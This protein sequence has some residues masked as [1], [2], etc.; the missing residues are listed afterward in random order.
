MGYVPDGPYVLNS[1]DHANESLEL[2]A[3]NDLGF[4]E[5]QLGI[6]RKKDKGK[7]EV[8]E[9]TKHLEWELEILKNVKPT[10]ICPICE[11]RT[12]RYF[13]IQTIGEY[14]RTDEN[15]MCCLG[16]R[17]KLLE[18]A[19]F[20]NPTLIPLAFPAMK[21]FYRYNY[22]KRRLIP[23]PTIKKI[24]KIFKKAFGIEKVNRKTMFEWLKKES[25]PITLSRFS[26]DLEGIQQVIRY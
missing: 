20:E 7:K 21:R 4:L 18:K 19:Q 3:L 24:K 8:S 26:I 17:D 9:I 16:C 12:V 5:Q 22:K 2:L 10:A 1:G 15:H 11:S 25:R 13:M 14:T 6:R 23:G